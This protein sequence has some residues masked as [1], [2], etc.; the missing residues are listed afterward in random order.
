MDLSDLLNKEK[1]RK[2]EASDA[3]VKD[4]LKASERDLRIAREMLGKNLDWAFN[5]AYNSMIVAGRAL[6]FREGYTPSGEDHHRTVIEYVDVK[7]GKNNPAL[8]E[9]FKK[10][11]PKR[12]ESVYFSAETISEYEAKHAIESAGKLLVLIKEKIR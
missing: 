5:I 2:I 3:E 4:C 12:H 8:I 1:I 9:Y 7:F 6:M 11:R 10:M